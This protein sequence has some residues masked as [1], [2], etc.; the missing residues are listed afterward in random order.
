[1]LLSKKEIDLLDPTVQSW[2]S[3]K[4]GLKSNPLFQFQYFC[5]AVFVS[6][7]LKPKLL[8]ISSNKIS[9]EVFQEILF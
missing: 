9:K 3:A 2:V 8:Y 5:M 7:L 1:M 6:K 4:P